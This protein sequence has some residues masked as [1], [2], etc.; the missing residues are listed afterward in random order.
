MF[1]QPNFSSASQLSG[2]SANTS[3]VIDLDQ[4]SDMD[5]IFSSYETNK[6][7]WLE[8]NENE[9]LNQGAY[10]VHDL[11]EE[12]QLGNPLDRISSIF[13][14]DFDSDGDLDII[15]SGFQNDMIGVYLNDGTEGFEF[16]EIGNPNGPLFVTVVDLDNNG[17]LDIVCASLYDNTV[18][19]YKTEPVDDSGQMSYSHEIISNSAVG[20]ASLAVEDIDND[21]D[22]DV[23]SAGCYDSNN[24]VAIYFN[25][26]DENFSELVINSDNGAAYADVSVADIFQGGNLE[27]VAASSD[28]K[29]V[30]LFYD[31]GD[32]S[33]S[34]S[35]V[36][37]DMYNVNYSQI[38]DMDSDNDLDI[39]F[40]GYD[41]GSSQTVFG[42]L[43]N[44]GNGS[45]NEEII[46]SF[47]QGASIRGSKVADLDND[48]DLDILYCSSLQNYEGVYCLENI[49]VNG[50]LV[51]DSF[52]EGIFD[53]GNYG[54][55]MNQNADPSIGYLNTTATDFENAQCVKIDYSVHN[56][57]SWGGF[58]HAQRNAPDEFWD[59]SQYNTI[60][61]NYFNS[62]PPDQTDRVE[63]R[64]ILDDIDDSGFYSF[65]YILDDVSN[66]WEK[67]EIPLIN[68][69]SWNGNGFNYTGWIG[70][71]GDGIMDLSQ[72]T[73]Y[74]LEF[75]I[76][77]NGES[78]DYQS[79]TIYLDEL[80]LENTIPRY[81]VT[82]QFDARSLDVHPAGIH[83]AGNFRNI[84]YDDYEE[85]PDAP[86][87][88]DFGV[89]E[90]L[91]NGFWSI[92]LELAQG[93]Y[94]YKFINGNEWADEHDLFGDEL[95]CTN[96]DGSGFYNRLVS[97]NAD[98][99]LAPVCLNSCDPC[100]LSEIVFDNSLI[101]SSYS[102]ITS[103]E[104]DYLS[105]SFNDIGYNGRTV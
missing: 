44:D 54:Y 103:F 16:I 49:S 12:S 13:S 45:F 65:H 50:P 42:I 19:W 97:V 90:D 58:V 48:Q 7:Y 21:G 86:D 53:S 61:F 62:I 99:V 39:V 89:L 69:G 94:Q 81:P 98:I 29:R 15:A 4:D 3:F 18:Q 73:K 77:T 38:F 85:N 79:G 24:K 76:N 84:E 36:L 32:L 63:F 17:F 87:W 9:D 22:L 92:T 71:E 57:E 31:S 41:A 67:V 46:G 2:I 93:D 82:F 88:M 74:S 43:K 83:I 5:I 72:I 70:T 26:G 96:N 34:N 8:K 28:N 59:W 35:T 10:T 60:S 56:N 20:P 40:S 101:N 102:I 30:T 68:N 104:S 51:I 11:N 37:T 52:D 91:G 64:L 25:D 47:D 66:Q 33:Y 14:I 23:V 100:D 75:S 27:I 80:Q 78:G 1:S 55:M 95:S 6:I 105:G